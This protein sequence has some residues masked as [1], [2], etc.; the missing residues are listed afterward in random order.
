[1][2]GIRELR[3]FFFNKLCKLTYL[4]DEYVLVEASTLLTVERVSNDIN[5]NDQIDALAALQW[6][7]VI[8]FLK[9]Q[10]SQ[11]ES[12]CQNIKKT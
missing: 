5:A 10:L 11:I 3:C 7:F 9:R 8:N 12:I 1:M 6:V 4:L 2:L